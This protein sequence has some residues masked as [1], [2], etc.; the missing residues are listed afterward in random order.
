[1]LKNLWF[2]TCQKSPLA[3]SL[4]QLGVRGRFLSMLKNTPRALARGRFLTLYF[5][6]SI[7]LNIKLILICLMAEYNWKLISY[8]SIPVG[9]VMGWIF[10]APLNAFV[11]HILLAAALLV[12]WATVYRL[13][14][15]QKKANAFTSSALI[16]LIVMLFYIFRSIS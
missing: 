4:L 12:I 3:R 6:Q 9:L 2:L 14:S 10:N 8:F 7:S 11:K 15:S 13:S 16:A 5:T 1:M